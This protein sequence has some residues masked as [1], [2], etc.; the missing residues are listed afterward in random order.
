MRLREIVRVVVTPMLCS[1]ISS[2]SRG[3]SM[4][5]TFCWRSHGVVDGG[6]GEGAG[7]NKDSF[8]RLL[9]GQGSDK[10]LDFLTADTAL[11][12]L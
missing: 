7:R 11:P 8:V 2:A 10:A 12:P 5:M 9:P 1:I 4:R 3:P 6:L